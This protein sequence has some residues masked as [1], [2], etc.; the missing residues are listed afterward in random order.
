MSHS[1]HDKL[2]EIENPTSVRTLARAPFRVLITITAFAIAFVWL[3]RHREVSL[4][5]RAMRV[6]FLYSD[7]DI[8]VHPEWI[9]DRDVMFIRFRSDVNRFEFTRMNADTGRQA[10]MP[11]LNRKFTKYLKC[12]GLVSV[13]RDAGAL[14]ALPLTFSLSP[15]RTRLLVSARSSSRVTEPYDQG[16]D[17]DLEANSTRQWVRPTADLACPTSAPSSGD[18]REVSVSPAGKHLAWLIVDFRMSPLS[19]LAQLVRTRTSTT[20]RYTIWVSNL[21]GSEAKML[22]EEWHQNASRDEIGIESI[23]WLRS[24]KDLSFVYAGG[25]Y[26]LPVER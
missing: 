26:T 14:R 4:L 6:G 18:V 9:S 21:D 13:D 20:A 12:H 15:T 7:G 22:A 2:N 11:K 16:F 8:P 24:G 17:I 19:T 25:L 1:H 5:E 3:V 10:P 23:S